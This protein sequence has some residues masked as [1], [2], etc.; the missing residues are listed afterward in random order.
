MLVEGWKLRGS[1]NVVLY[2][3]SGMFTILTH[4]PSGVELL[5]NC[6]GRPDTYCG[7]QSETSL[8][9]HPVFYHSHLQLLSLGLL[10]HPLVSQFSTACSGFLYDSSTML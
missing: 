5:R 4:G 8:N 9:P 2:E 3:S 7:E 1:W 10:G 6:F